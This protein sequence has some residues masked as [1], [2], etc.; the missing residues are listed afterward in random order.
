MQ[1][2]LP[3]PEV[4][5]SL[6]ALDRMRLGNQRSHA[7]IILGALQGRHPVLAQRLPAVRMWRGHEGFLAR[8]GFAACRLWLLDRNTLEPDA[9]YLYF[10]DMVKQYPDHARPPWLGTEALH[11]SHRSR[12]IQKAPGRYQPIWPDVPNDLPLVW[13][14]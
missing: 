10:A 14:N 13:P 7:K 6:V 8:Y 12:L 9:L 11:L 3:Y 5:T 1:T 4:T 2:F